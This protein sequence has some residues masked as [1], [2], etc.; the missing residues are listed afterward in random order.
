MGLHTYDQVS[1]LVDAIPADNNKIRELGAHVAVM[2][3]RTATASARF[4]ALHSC[5]RLATGTHPLP[6]D[7]VPSNT[8][9]YNHSPLLSVPLNSPTPVC[10]N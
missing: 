10:C 3:D 1:S 6:Y 9:T 8:L 2:K 7:P 5:E 4:T